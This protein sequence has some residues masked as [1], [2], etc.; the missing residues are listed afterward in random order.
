MVS[1]EALPGLAVGVSID[2]KTAWQE[3]Y[4]WADVE[5]ETSIDPD[6]TLF[7][8]G[9][10]SKTLTGIGLLKLVESGK[11]D[12]KEQIYAY[13]PEFPM[14][15]YP[16]NVEQVAKHVAGIRHYR[17]WEF[18]SNV[19]Y[20]DVSSGLSIFTGDTLLFEPGTQYSYSSYGWNLIS[21][22]METASGEEF[23]SYM[24]NSVFE[25]AN[26]NMTT[27]ENVNKQY[28]PI[29]TFY[30]EDGNPA[31]PVDN[32]YKWAGGG[33]ISTLSDMLVFG[34]A[35][36]DNS[37]IS[38]ETMKT[39]LDTYTLKDGQKTNRGVGFEVQTDKKGRSW[40]GHS[41]GSV[42]GTTML[43]IY[44]EYDMVIVTLCNKS[45]AGTVN[46]AFRIAD[47]F[48]TTLEEGKK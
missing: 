9:S 15:R 20:S 40:Y 12:L 41:G 36:L 2:G 16:V 4:G 35:I 23:L 33:F 29:V 30:Q 17:G 22:A 21:R 24:T 39:A 14:K 46:L 26:M 31:P 37:L 6:A 13:V 1:S 34:N 42:G 43:L 38:A 7:R 10:V 19:H 47:Q 25:P 32:S 45:R 3:S 5:T 8:V 44:P 18:M 48:L 28:P 27:A 11:I